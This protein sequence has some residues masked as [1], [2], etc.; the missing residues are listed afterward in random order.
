MDK[1]I[2]EQRYLKAKAIIERY[3]SRNYRHE[4]IAK[5]LNVPKNIVSRVTKEFNYE[6][7]KHKTHENINDNQE[8]NMV[9][10]YEK[11]DYLDQY[12]FKVNNKYNSQAK[13]E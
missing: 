9:V 2:I 8:I 7:T 1:N 10:N 6:H 3:T 11:M 4:D 13:R 5:E 12:D